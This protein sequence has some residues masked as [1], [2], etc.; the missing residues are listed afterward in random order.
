M[1]TNKFLT[2]GSNGKDTLTTAISASTGAGDASKIVATD[3]TGRID[4]TLMP[5]GIGADTETIA[6]TENLA[7]GD[8]VNIFNN[9][10][11]R[12]VRKAGVDNNRPANG[13][14]LSAVTSGQ[15]ATV[16]KSGT[17]TGLSSLTHGT[18]YFLGNNGAATATPAIA[19]PA[20]LI[21]SLGYASDTTEIL[22]VFQSPTLIA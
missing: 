1:S 8:F 20:Q 14:V 11:T 3:G 5:V 17:N 21:Q 12:G 18:E 6:A 19:A 13:F 7:A 15:N 22:F 4:S 2:I 9:T 16:Y 10:G